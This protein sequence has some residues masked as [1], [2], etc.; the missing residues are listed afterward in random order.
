[1]ILY[2]FIYL[3]I[4]M[5]IA[6]VHC[7][8]T[9]GWAA[10]V[11]QDLID[12]QKDIDQ[13]KVFTLFSDSKKFKTQYH[14]LDIVT[15]LPKRINN[16]FL[17]CGKHKIPVLSR[18]FDYRNLMFF[19]PTLMRI[20]S[21]K[22]KRYKPDYITIS[23]FAIAKN[24]TPISW[25]PMML[26]L[27]SPMQYI[28]THYDEYKE[29]LTGIKWK[30]FNRIVPRLRKRDLKF[31][32]FDKIFAN[33]KYTAKEAEKLYKI[34]NIHIKYPRIPNKFFVPAVQESPQEYYLYVGRL[35][36]F[37]READKIIRLC[38]EMKVP[39]I[40]MGSGPDEKYLKSIAGP[41]IIFIGWIQDI[42]EKIKIISQAK[43]LINLTKES[44]GIGTVEAL[45]LGVPIFGYSQWATAELVDKDCGILVENKK[46]HTLIE[47]FKKFMN[48][49]RDRM[50][51]AKRIR[52]KWK[53]R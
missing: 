28:W 4:F 26:Y 20:L 34:N 45:L 41:G 11:L 32:K 19:Y 24:I 17:W 2:T 33:S 22:I 52:E 44:Y 40:V 25:V 3:V 49:K 21:K 51:I 13:A 27:H 53:E 23:S 14:T 10:A 43:W 50:M 6:F 29:K 48:T 36:S 38:N 39:L 7:W 1:M 37:V 9:P 42:D 47:E 46:H 15:A 31:T 8:I 16:L 18:L 5:K 35:V 12:E 30:L